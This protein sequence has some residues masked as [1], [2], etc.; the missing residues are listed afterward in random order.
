[1]VLK[2]V[3]AEG[4]SLKN[5][6]TYRNGWIH[7]RIS[8]ICWRWIFV[9]WIFTLRPWWLMMMLLMLWD[10]HFSHF[11]C[12]L[13]LQLLSIFLFCICFKLCS[14]CLPLILMSRKTY[15]CLLAHVSS[16]NK[17]FLFKILLTFWQGQFHW[18]AFFDFL[19][20]VWL[21]LSFVQNEL[22]IQSSLDRRNQNCPSPKCY[23][24]R[25]KNK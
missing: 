14:L 23:K 10:I 4:T 15:K 17:N 5:S 25:L 3:W 22:V 7:C 21:A 1:M 20:L 6:E 9:R 8:W 18:L 19:G 2:T 12:I 16:K 13:W 24:S 11:I